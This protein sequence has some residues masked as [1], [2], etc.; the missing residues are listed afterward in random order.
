MSVRDLFYLYYLFICFGSI[1]FEKEASGQK[2]R[3]NREREKKDA[4]SRDGPYSYP[5]NQLFCMAAGNLSGY[6]DKNPTIKKS[7]REKTNKAIIL[8]W[9]WDRDRK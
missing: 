7:T 5:D 4:K 3:R 9:I 2:R 6:P 8:K 1:R